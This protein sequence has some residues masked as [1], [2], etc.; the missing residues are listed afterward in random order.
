VARSHKRISPDY[1]IQ[2]SH[3]AAP[4]FRAYLA[5]SSLH[6]R[7]EAASLSLSE[8]KDP[9]EKPVPSVSGE[10]KLRIEVAPE[11][12]PSFNESRYEIVVFV[13]NQRFDE[14]E[15]AYTP[16]TYTLDTTKLANGE[17]VITINLVNLM[18]PTGSYTFRLNV[19]N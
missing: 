19:N 8:Q 9:S 4:K 5:E 14:E 7:R 11:S 3:S 1:F 18:G 6:A 2:R 17:H 12:L 16:Y 10:A 15:S 13:D